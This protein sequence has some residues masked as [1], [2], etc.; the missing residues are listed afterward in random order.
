MGAT[1]NLS[2]PQGNTS[3]VLALTNSSQTNRLFGAVQV[4]LANHG[5]RGNT[6][7][8]LL[9]GILRVPTGFL[10]YLFLFFYGR[11]DGVLGI[12]GC[13]LG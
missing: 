8:I 3:G 4:I 2:D 7:I 11:F 6:G 9:A 5:T 12:G 1:I 13:V 10:C